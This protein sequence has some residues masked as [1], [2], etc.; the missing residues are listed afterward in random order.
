MSN[1]NLPSAFISQLEN[2]LGNEAEELI[3]SFCTDS[4]VSIRINL[5]KNYFPPPG[6]K[7]VPWCRTGYYLPARPVFTLDPAFHA[8]GYYVQEASSMFL[9]Q[10][11]GKIIKENKP[12][13]ALDIS[14]APGGKSTHLL[15]LLPGE[16]LVVCNE[17]IRSRA[18]ILK[19]N[20]I[21]WGLSNVIVTSSDPEKFSELKN[22][23]DIILVD[24]PCS[25]EGLFRK[26]AEAVNEWSQE[27]ID[28]CELR[29]KRILKNVWPALKAGG[30]LIYSTCTFQKSEN[31]EQ[32]KRFAD[33][34][35]AHSV[36][37]DINDDWNITETETPTENGNLIGY[38]FY[39]HK[40]KGE[41]FFISVLQKEKE[42]TS[43]E[44]KKTKRKLKEIKNNSVNNYISNPEELFFF[45]HNSVIFTFPRNLKEDLTFLSDKINIIYAGVETGKIKGKD[46][47]PAHALALSTIVSKNIP[48]F[49][50]SS[51]DALKYLRKNEIKIDTNQK[52]WM[53]VKHNNLNLGWIKA[54]GNRINN[55]YPKEYRIRI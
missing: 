21:K 5:F 47:I 29:Q 24:A 48:Y 45:E 34:N 44:N 9:E 49:E 54:L 18:E 10:S 32:L 26:D 16:S 50:L 25:G 38:R 19:E 17:V 53:I 41:G 51:E 46:L 6:L 39:P 40:L 14:A 31:E 12:V 37:I 2:L 4:P 52:G 1:L 36:S 11:I 43:T 20:I 15:S 33:A 42:D 8:G 27:N 55:Y 35:N 22:Y 23:F 28:L 30:F 3:A 13:K 7:Q